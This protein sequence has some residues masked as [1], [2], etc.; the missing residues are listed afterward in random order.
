M[1]GRLTD[2]PRAHSTNQRPLEALRDLGVEEEVMAEAVPR[3]LMGN[4]LARPDNYVAFRET[5]REGSA[6][7]HAEAE[8]ALESALRTVLDRAQEVQA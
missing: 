7:S 5:F 1:Y 6:T 3:E 4:L 2:T 8:A